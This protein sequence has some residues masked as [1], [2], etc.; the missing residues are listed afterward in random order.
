MRVDG[1]IRVSRVGGRGGES[2]ISPDEQ[3]RAI[4]AY[5]AA[6]GLE[7]AAWHSDLDQSGGTLE[8][9]GFQA[10]LER[11]RTGETGGIIAAKLDRLTRSTVGLGTL[12]ER[13]RAGG[14]NLIAVDFG[15]D[16]FSANG[17][18]VADVLAAV[19]E[20]ERTRRGD[21]WTAAR[22]NAIARGVFGGSHVPIGYRR[23]E[24]GRL[25]VLEE[26]AEVV[27]EAF[28]RRAAGASIADVARF[29]TNMGV[30]PPDRRIDADGWAHSTVRQILAN[31]VYLGVVRS[32]DFVNEDAHPAIVTRA[33]F[34]AVRIAK[35]DR[36]IPPGEFSHDALVLGIA[37][38]HGCGHT[39]KIV[40][41]MRAD[42][43]AVVSYYCKNAA[44]VA[45]VSRAFVHVPALDTL[46]EDFFL[47]ALRN[48]D[49]I[50][51]S[52]EAE[53]DV[54]DAKAAVDA[55]EAELRAFVTTASA[56]AADLFAAGCEARQARVDM[57]RLA[58]AETQS[59]SSALPVPG[60][61]LAAL[62]TT[63][64][65]SEKRKIL[66]AYLDRV[67]VARGDGRLVD[68]V[69]IVWHGNVLADP[70]ACLTL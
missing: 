9:P 44:S 55:A 58:L 35:T 32:G 12:I 26:E 4:E 38:C 1:Y 16:L 20:W 39:L 42:G 7:I 68:R 21:D 34:D 22:A 30:R 2:F 10:A 47:D 15:L 23:G 27:R 36:P 46:I 54:A 51:E 3:R 25:V 53:K 48:D 40:R 17:K 70:R 63:L 67:V 18:L 28:D 5:A 57:S 59:R 8:R 29:F 43:S 24:S 56:L 65:P 60:G 61:N 49:R 37:R 69:Q 6:H 13:A 66:A 14:W 19:A 50:A 31:D 41:R 33:E 11:C 62:W 45:C 64:E 52:L